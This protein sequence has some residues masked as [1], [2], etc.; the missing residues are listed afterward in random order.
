MSRPQKPLDYFP[1]GLPWLCVLVQGRSTCRKLGLLRAWFYA[2]S[3]TLSRR[4]QG[5]AMLFIKEDILCTT[6]YSAGGI[7]LLMV[8][9][10]LL[11]GRL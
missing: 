11:T 6:E 1:G 10:L 8:L 9:V 4:R 5:S 3:L 2:H 7:I